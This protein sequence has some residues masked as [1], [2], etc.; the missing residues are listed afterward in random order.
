MLVFRGIYH[1]SIYI[2]R[3]YKRDRLY[4][5]GSNERIAVRGAGETATGQTIIST[6][7]AV[8][9]ERLE[10][11]AAEHPKE[12]GSGPCAQAILP[13]TWTSRP[14]LEKARRESVQCIGAFLLHPYGV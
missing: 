11:V 2:T 6:A 12:H 10:A 13:V 8:S 14:L 5:G 1:A 7:F 3:T 4:V 9:W